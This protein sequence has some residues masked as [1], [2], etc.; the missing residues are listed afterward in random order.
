MN[1]DD[2]QTT[3]YYKVLQ[4]INNHKYETENAYQ[5]KSDSFIKTAF[6][7]ITSETDKIILNFFTSNQEIQEVYATL[8]KHTLRL[9]TD[10]AYDNVKETFDNVLKKFAS[11]IASFFSKN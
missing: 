6:N 7:K 8:K 10:S 4:I 3:I 11:G 2:L 5:R 1:K 9:L